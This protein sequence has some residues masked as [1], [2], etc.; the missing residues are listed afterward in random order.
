MLENHWKKGHVSVSAECHFSLADQVKKKKMYLL[1]DV[2]HLHVLRHN[3]Q[4][5]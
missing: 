3:I 2:P 1:F 5:K 4:S